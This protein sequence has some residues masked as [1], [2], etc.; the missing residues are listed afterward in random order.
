MTLGTRDYL[1]NRTPVP[2]GTLTKLFFESVD[3]FESKTAFR[4]IRDDG[5]DEFSYEDIL[6]ITREVSG[7]LDK[8]TMVRFAP[9]FPSFPSIPP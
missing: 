8:R 2:T 1:A 5:F 7:G 9:G 4:A 6:A 3:R